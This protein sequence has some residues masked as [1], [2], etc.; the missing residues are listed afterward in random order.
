MNS[1]NEFLS[2][3][4]DLTSDV[5]HSTN[6]F[7]TNN[8]RRWYYFLSQW[9]PASAIV[10]KLESDVDYEVWKTN[11]LVENKGM[12][13]GRISLPPETASRLGIQLHLFRTFLT[14]DDAAWRFSSD[15]VSGNTNTNDLIREL[16]YQ[17]FEP[18]SRDLR[19][20][21]SKE[22]SEIDKIPASDR[23]VEINHNAPETREAIDALKALRVALEQANDYPDQEDKAQRIAEIEAGLV[24]IRAPRVRLEAIRSVVF[25]SAKYLAKK[26][27]DASIGIVAKAVISAIAKLFGIH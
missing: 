20:H 26:F 8:L 3:Y 10:S 4:D 16:V 12:G 7:F 14:D 24:L 22:W 11:G 15:F 6:D 5:R 25:R 19:R 13:H 17:L 23:F 1:L 9:K 21:F 18:F 27:T 2:E